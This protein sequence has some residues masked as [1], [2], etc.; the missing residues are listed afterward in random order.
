MTYRIHM[1]S[2]ENQKDYDDLLQQVD[3]LQ[4][5]HHKVIYQSP[6]I[7]FECD[8]EWVISHPT[9]KVLDLLK[10]SYQPKLSLLSYCTDTQKENFFLL[11]QQA[12]DTS[13]PIQRDLPISNSAGNEL[14]VQLNAQW[15]DDR[16]HISLN[17]ITSNVRNAELVERIKAGLDQTQILCICDI[18]GRLTYVNE[19]FC[20]IS[21]YETEE[22]IGQNLSLLKSDVHG[23]SFYEQLQTTLLP[24][25]RWEGEICQ[26][27]KDQTQ[28][29]LNTTI[30]PMLDASGSPHHYI[31][32]SQ[33]ITAQ[34]SLMQQM[35][36][37]RLEAEVSS[38]RL[39]TFIDSSVDGI[40]VIDSKGTILEYNHSSEKIFGF[41]RE[42]TLGKTIEEVL[43]PAR[44][45]KRHLQGVERLY[46]TKQR[47][48]AGVSIEVTA[49]RKGGG[50]IPIEITPFSYEIDGQFILAGFVRDNTEKKIAEISIRSTMRQLEIENKVW[51]MIDEAQSTLLKSSDPLSVLTALLQV[52]GQGLNFDLVQVYRLDG[53]L[54][55]PHLK[56]SAHWSKN[57]EKYQGFIEESRNFHG[58]KGDGLV[59]RVWETQQIEWTQDVSSP[60]D[61][62]QHQTS[63]DLFFHSGVAVPI[64]VEGNCYGVLEAFSEELI[65]ADPALTRAFG[66]A[67]SYF[68]KIIEK[69]LH[70][71]RERALHEQMEAHTR[72]ST[73]GELSS[74]I[75]HEINNPL[76]VLSGQAQKAL[77]LLADPSSNKN[78]VGVSLQKIIDHSARIAKIVRSLRI[79][80]H[81]DSQDPFTSY[82]VKA[83]I[84]D[85][86]EICKPLA[87]L[88]SIDIVVNDF[89][90]KLSLECRPGQLSQVLVNLI[91][92]SYDAISN[93]KEKWISVSV[94]DLGN[95]ICFTVTDSGR[96]LP[97]EVAEKA[98]NPFFTTKPTGK[99]TG[100]GLSVS[101]GIVEAHQGSIEVDRTHPNTRFS[102]T[103]PRAQSNKQ[104]A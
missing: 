56:L 97:P 20:K 55:T 11:A 71:A 64:T 61:F 47:R 96:G 75:A 26:T 76:M 43:V 22:I 57:Q 53:T 98:F 13:E 67:A 79:F 30:F 83:L 73:L 72:M 81:D 24:G 35:H 10:V 65:L 99:G 6:L 103:L 34:K 50:E 49:L 59:G 91:Q 87:R 36:L 68:S 84:E 14:W 89:D 48:L 42:E 27:A 70:E 45:K 33:N 21:K 102:F 17:N 69:Q 104:V 12:V 19:S 1:K 78:E 38:K 85:T 66:L 31:Y 23:T 3:K 40:L 86:L 88:N 100:L 7:L 52:V 15:L 9:Q 32:I 58:R 4:Q 39:Q 5:L 62:P 54:K 41:S 94:S 77:H 8:L 37:K 46:T 95:Q 60:T 28:Y 92:N 18:H 63:D 101:K 93:L 90:P 44:F 74:G 29:W 80:S 16:L 2:L 25:R 82:E 51:S